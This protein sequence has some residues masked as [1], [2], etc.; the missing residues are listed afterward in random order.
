MMKKLLIFLLMIIVLLTACAPA[1]PAGPSPTPVDVAAIQTE[2]VQTVIAAVTQTA[3]VLPTE[4]PGPPTET[5][6]PTATVTPTPEDTPTATPVI[7]NNAIYVED[8]TIPDETE[9]NPGQRF[10]KTWKVKNTGACGWTRAYSLRYAF[11]ERMGGLIT[12]LDNI[13]PA[14][15]EVD[16]SIQLVAPQ[17]PG[18]YRGY[19]VLYDNNGYT[20]GEY[21]SVIIVVP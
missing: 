11:G 6:V 14:D 4:T 15:D 12:Y 20:F 21:L 5:P 13:V 7:C 10:T 1:Q 19:W 9:V 17:R 16:I 8:V 2:A 3:A 18:T